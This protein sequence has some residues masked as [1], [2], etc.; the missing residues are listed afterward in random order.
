M[1]SSSLPIINF[2]LPEGNAELFLSIASIDGR[3][4]EEREQK[5]N[6]MKMTLSWNI[7]YARKPCLLIGIYFSTY[8]QTR[9]RYYRKVSPW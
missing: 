5:C 1:I 3:I 9:H 2:L 7:P 8:Y 4:P 6:H